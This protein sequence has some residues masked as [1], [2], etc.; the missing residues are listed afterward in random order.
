MAIALDLGGTQVRAALVDAAGQ[1]HKRVGMAT[2]SSIGGDAVIDQLVAAAREVSREVSASDLI[3]VGVSSPGPLDSV[4]GVT[5]GLP[6]IPGF[7][8]MPLR[9]RLTGA[10]DLTVT[11]EN[12][13][14][15]AAVGE[16][17]HGAGRELQHLVY[18]TVSTGRG[19]G[20]IADGRVLRGRRG[21]AGHVGHLS[22]VKDGL[23]CNCGNPGCWEAYGA[24]PALARRARERL[25]DHPRSLLATADPLDARAVFAAADQDDAMAQSLI[26]EE[27]DI[28]GV[29]IVSLL[30]LY[31][32]ERVILGGGLAN[33]FARLQPGIAARIQTDAMP[34]F[35]DV[36]VVVAAL[37]GN[38][39]LIGAAALAFERA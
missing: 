6:S 17:R 38:S 29:G 11:V 9:D 30:H 14:I 31:S 20:V 39:G 27:A 23:R 28:L 35:R 21:M 1:I 12:D 25:Q 24:G 7:V 26:A 32:P 19:G 2:A 22:I 3:G 34:A 15:A 5:L 16:W 18:V 8:D 10:L 33:G 37:S 4:T 36:P 13:G